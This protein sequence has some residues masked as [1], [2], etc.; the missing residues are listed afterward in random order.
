MIEARKPDIFITDEKEESCIIVNIAVPADGRVHG[1]GKGEEYQELRR[2]IGRMCQL[3][4]VWVVPV[5]LASLGNVAKELNRWMEKLGVL[6]DVGAMQNCLVRKD[7]DPD[8]GIRDVREGPP[9]SLESFI[10]IRIRLA[11][12]MAIPTAR[13]CFNAHV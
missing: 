5:V 11:V 13:S 10:A 8:D 1:K 12:M 9:L 2:R 6:G 3:E 4:R 7:K